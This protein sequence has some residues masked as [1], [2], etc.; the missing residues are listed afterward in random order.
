MI[1]ILVNYVAGVFKSFEQFKYA[2]LFKL[3]FVNEMFLLNWAI[4]VP[5]AHASVPLPVWPV[6]GFVCGFV[7]GACRPTPRWLA[8]HLKQCWDRSCSV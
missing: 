3:T 7:R 6:R 5:F 4:I 8:S 1:L 2:E